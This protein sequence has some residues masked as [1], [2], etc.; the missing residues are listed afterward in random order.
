[1]KTMRPALVPESERSALQETE[2][3][4]SI[5]GMKESILEGMKT[6]LED[7]V[8]IEEVDLLFEER[9]PGAP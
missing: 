6:P 1:M 2:Y 7:C 5:P 8:E 9:P 4:L 3:L